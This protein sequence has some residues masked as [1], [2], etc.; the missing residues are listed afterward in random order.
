MSRVV[1]T[2]KLT[3]VLSSFDN[4]WS[5]KKY[6]EAKNEIFKLAEFIRDRDEPVVLI[7]NLGASAWSW[8][9]HDLESYA[10]LKPQGKI[11]ASGADLPFY[12]R[13]PTDHIYTHPGIETV[14]IEMNDFLGTGHPSVTSVF[15]IAPLRKK[16]KLLE[17]S[18]ILNE[19]ELLLPPT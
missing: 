11:W 13:R 12:S 4:P 19:Q 5:E 14:N 1:E 8:L 18:P 2:R 15:K 6:A 16:I 3:L 17:L 7:G 9:L 10:G